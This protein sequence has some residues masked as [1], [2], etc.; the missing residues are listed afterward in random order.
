MAHIDHHSK[1]YDLG[2]LNK[3]EIFERYIGNW[4]PTFIMQPQFG[5]INIV[6]FFSGLG[7][8]SNG[9]SGSAI[10][11]LEMIKKFQG[12]LWQNETI[13]NLYLNEYNCEKFEQLQKNCNAFL[14]KNSSIKRF[15]KVHYSCKDF[16][17]IYD[18]IIIKTQKKPNLYIIDQSG[19]KFTNQENFNTLLKLEMTDF[20]FF[21]SSS[22]FKRFNSEDEFNRHLNINEEDLNSNPYNFI[23]RIVLDKYRSLIPRNSKLRIFPFSIKKNSNIY[24]IIFGSKHILGVEKFLKIAWDK[25]NINGEA[26]Y[27]IDDDKGKSQYVINFENPH[28][29]RKMTKIESFKAKLEAFIKENKEVSSKDLYFFTYENG[30]ISDHTNEHLRELRSKKIISYNGHTRISWSSVR[31][32]KITRFKWV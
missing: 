27:D 13:I 31:D 1:P 28:A 20:L 18:E 30:H 22:F 24:G 16:N 8:D 3:L 2:T 11:T 32:S 9:I 25:N 23:H 21:I 7:Y 17:E 6:D 15:V 14:D 5:E 29:T 4:L 12:M 19:I 10:R 26:D